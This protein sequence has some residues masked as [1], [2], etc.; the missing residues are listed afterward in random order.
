MS[1]CLHF[2]LDQVHKF[3]IHIVRRSDMGVRTYTV[4]HTVSVNAFIAVKQYHDHSNSSHYH[5]GVEHGRVKADVVLDL[6]VLPL[7]DNRKSS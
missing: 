4:I 2:L 5:H 6:R 1:H 3:I 7:A